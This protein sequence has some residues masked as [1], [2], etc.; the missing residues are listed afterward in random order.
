M[1]VFSGVSMILIGSALEGIA[2]VSLKIASSKKSWRY[3][4]WTGFG[5]TLFVIE[6]ALYT[7]ALKFLDIAVAYPLNA[8][9]Y[10][11]VLIAS[12]M[13]LNEK[14]D[15]R[16]WLGVGCIVAGAALAIPE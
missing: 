7:R 5:S 6:I 14:T 15:W 13:L 16:R 9:S 1:S 11:A 4:F 8:L 12:R 10:A 2:Q 3:V